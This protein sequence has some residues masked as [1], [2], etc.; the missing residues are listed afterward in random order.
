[1]LLL[2]LLLLLLLKLFSF[3]DD[4]CLLTA[5]RQSFCRFEF[6]PAR[7]PRVLMLKRRQQFLAF[8]RG[9]THYK[10]TLDSP[11]P[12]LVNSCYHNTLILD[13]NYHS[14]NYS[15]AGNS[16]HMTRCRVRLHSRLLPFDFVLHIRNLEEFYL[17]LFVYA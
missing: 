8:L 16:F 12:L 15:T 13:N 17:N 9:F 10:H 7:W 14:P 1:M 4:L 6:F 3:Y 11:S 2:L 5:I